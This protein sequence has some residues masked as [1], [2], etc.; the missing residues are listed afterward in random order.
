[1]H[2]SCTPAGAASVALLGQRCLE[3]P[4]CLGCAQPEGPHLGVT[5]HCVQGAWGRQKVMLLG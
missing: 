5:C 1:M 4:G 3:V 2:S